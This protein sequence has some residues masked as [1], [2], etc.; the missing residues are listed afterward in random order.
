M[1]PIR[2]LAFLILFI[3]IPFFLKLVKDGPIDGEGDK[4]IGVWKRSSNV[5]WCEPNY[6]LTPYIAEFGNSISSLTIVG[7]GLYGMYRHWNTVEVR[8]LAAFAVFILVG[9]GSAMFHGTLL[10]QWQLADEL[11]MVWGNGIFVYCLLT[12]E[13]KPNV[14]RTSYIIILIIVELL[15]NIA[16]ILFD[17]EDQTIFLV[18]YGSGV[19][20]LMYHSYHL[21]LKYNGNYEV[22]LFD[23]AIVCYVG[24]FFLWLIDRL[25][26]HETIPGIG[27]TIRSL[28]LHSFWHLGAGNGTYLCVLF[29]IWTRCKYLKKK[30]QILRGNSLITSLQWISINDGEKIV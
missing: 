6:I 16:I 2:I 26:C 30:K 17:S 10:R 20:Y 9:F 22:A 14:K 18:C 1:G 19:F 4:G 24:G 7:N 25:Y 12:A 11:P 5:D 29:W 21:D 27:G 3:T 8:Y 23:T 28:Y 13:D 15:Q